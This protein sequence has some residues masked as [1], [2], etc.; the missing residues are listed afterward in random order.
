M[1]ILILGGTGSELGC[2]PMHTRQK[3]LLARLRLGESIK[4]VG[5]G[6]YLIQPLYVGDLAKAMVSSIGNE[7]TYN[8]IFCIAGPDVIENREYFEILGDISGLSI[9]IESVSEDKYHAE[10][11]DAYLYFCHRVYDLSKL[12]A[13]GLPIPSVGVRDGLKEQLDCLLG[14]GR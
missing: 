9:H 5:G 14:K 13:A 4:L 6:K 7:K 3:D 1:N 8:Q 12:S 11:D 10:H 2:F